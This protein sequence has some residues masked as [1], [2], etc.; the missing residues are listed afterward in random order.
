MSRRRQLLAAAD[1]IV[2]HAGQV[3]RRPLPAVD[4]V[5]DAI[6][7][8]VRASPDGTRLAAAVED[9]RTAIWNLTTGDRIGMLE[10]HNGEVLDVAFSPDSQFVITGGTE[11]KLK[12]WDATSLRELAT[13]ASNL[14]G[15]SQVSMWENG[16]RILKFMLHISKERQAERLRDRLE[17]PTKYWKFD[18][19]DLEDRARWDEFMAASGMS[20]DRS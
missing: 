13:F 3:Q 11:S 14:G 18:P 7:L 19:G 6:V 15:V 20:A 16:T 5:H 10:R 4:F 9:G 1:L 8:S 12:V 17:D 2:V